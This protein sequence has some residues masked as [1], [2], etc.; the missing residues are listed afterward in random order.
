MT[1]RLELLAPA[2]NTEI[3]IA[4]ID[5]GADAVYMAG[6]AFGAREAAGNSLEDVE[7][8]C[9]YAHRFGAKVYVTVNTIFY[10]SEK[11]EVSRLIRGAYEAGADALI[12]QDLGVLGLDL[13]PVPLHASTQTDIRT[14]Q[15]AAWLCSLGFE[16]IILARELSIEQIGRIRSAVDCSLEAFVHGALCVSYSGQCYLSQA[17]ASRSANRGCCVQACRSR[18]DLV[19]SQGRT[20]LHD[21]SILSLKDLRLDDRI[22]AMASAG[23]TS[24]KIEGRLKNASYIK[25]VVR[26][27][28]N[29]IDDV[30]AGS[31]RW[32]KSSWGHLCGGFQSDIEATFNRGFTRYFIDG[33]RGDWN[34]TD[35]AKSLGEYI[36]QV[37]AAD[38]GGIT[39]DSARKIENGDGLAFVTRSGEITGARADVCRGKHIKVKNAENLHSGMKIYRT[40]NSAFEKKL[41]NDMPVRYLQAEIAVSQTDGSLLFTAQCEDGA[42]ATFTFSGPLQ[43]ADNPQAA[44]E[45][46]RRQ[47]SRKSGFYD[48]ACGA[49]SLDTVPFFP[50]AAVNSIRRS[51]AEELAKTADNRPKAKAGPLKDR[52][53]RLSEDHLTYL[54]NC[55]NELSRKI[56]LEHGARCVDPAYEICAVP[57]A[58]VMRT[59]YC[60]RYRMGKCLKQH[61]DSKIA[62]PLYLVN[63]SRRLRLKFDCKNCEMVVIL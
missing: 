55:S 32:S 42:T 56:Y 63:N 22:E 61:P 8:M 18:Y 40:F 30:I 14:P 11:D 34:S 16:R 12:V 17:L 15:Q 28:R 7:R 46:I 47:L 5:C 13:P 62:E 60:I 10:D 38:A 19:D 4:A 21:R 41:E 50:V 48:F 35:A 36:G 59:K 49:I 9:R 45:T 26:H 31:T 39:V 1:D 57:G 25:N 44:L 52:G 54:A 58:E 23:V 24:F 2:R 27:Y 33:T 3:G 43:P 37:A 51:L 53:F 20:L 29:A 6:P